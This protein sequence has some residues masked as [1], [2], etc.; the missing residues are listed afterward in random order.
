MFH[1]HNN[2]NIVIKL[3]CLYLPKMHKSLPEFVQLQTVRVELQ[4][5]IFSYHQLWVA[6]PLWLKAGLVEEWGMVHCYKVWDLSQ[7]HPQWSGPSDWV[8]VESPSCHS[9]NNKN[10][11]QN[12]LYIKNVKKTLQYKVFIGNYSINCSLKLIVFSHTITHFPPVHLMFLL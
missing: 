2:K 5:P 6:F 4:L 3:L 7:H 9:K 1:S 12:N 11:N 10:K 8:C